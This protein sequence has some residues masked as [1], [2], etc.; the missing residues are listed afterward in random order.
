MKVIKKWDIIILCAILAIAI[1]LLCVFS[2]LFLDKGQHIIVKADGKEYARL[3]I[4]KDAQLLIE[5]K[6]GTNLLIIKDGKAYIE[7]ATCPK[8]I[9]VD[10]GELTELSPIV[11]KHNNVS[12][13]LE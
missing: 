4:N 13:T 12:I 2:F 8:Q 5:S 9:C 1:V 11:C 10:H 6:N 3:P 7:N